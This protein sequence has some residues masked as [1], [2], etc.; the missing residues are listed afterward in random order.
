[1]RNLNSRHNDALKAAHEWSKQDV[2]PVCLSRRMDKEVNE[3]VRVTER[4]IQAIEK[5]L[6]G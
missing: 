2:I 5:P 3:V 6:D 4:E 1:V